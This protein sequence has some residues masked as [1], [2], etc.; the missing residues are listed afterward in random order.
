M[1]TALPLCWLVAVAP[2]CHVAAAE[3][4]APASRSLPVD[5]KSAQQSQRAVTVKYSLIMPNDKTLERVKNDERNPF[6][7]PEEEKSVAKGSNEENAIRERLMKLRVSGARMDEQGNVSRVML[8]DMILKTGQALPPLVASQTLALKVGELAATSIELIWVEKKSS[9]LPPRKL[10]IPVDLR[11]SVH[12]KMAGQLADLNKLEGAKS[13]SLAQQYDREQSGPDPERMASASVKQTTP[14]DTAPV[15]KALAVPATDS[16]PA[17]DTQPAALTRDQ[18]ANPKAA[19]L[20]QAMGFLSQF[21][22][23]AK[24]PVKPSTSN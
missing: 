21:M 19:A 22:N 5:V 2:W 9:G 10:V 13:S 11:P 4:T 6:A 18:E 7:K 16:V 12:Y 20:K 23:S 17:T 24:P 1:K 3:S 14:E 15:T 8:G